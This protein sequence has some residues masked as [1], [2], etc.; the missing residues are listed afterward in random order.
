MSQKPT[1][2]PAPTVGL[3]RPPL[4]VPRLAENRRATHGQA[5]TNYLT[6]LVEYCDRQEENDELS[7]SQF[8]HVQRIR[9]AVVALVAYDKSS[10]ELLDYYRRS[11]TAGQEIA[12]AQVPSL[13]QALAP[14]W[15]AI[16]MRCFA[17]LEQHLPPREPS[18]LEKRIRRHLDQ[19][20]MQARAALPLEQRRALA[21]IN[22][23][24]L[25]QH[26]RPQ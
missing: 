1:P 15:E 6:P 8:E 18:D 23:Y 2:I 20:H 24:T 9:E 17:K 11:L 25:D 13:E 5:L 3:F 14:D 4:A 12:A 10:E 21:A 22:S 16:A 7:L 19:P 26:A